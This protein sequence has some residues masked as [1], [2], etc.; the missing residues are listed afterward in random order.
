MSRSYRLFDIMQALRRNREPV[1]ESEV[2][3]ETGVSLRTLYRGIAT[4]Q[5]MG[6]YIDGEPGIG[7]DRP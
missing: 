7:Y 6:A 1:S 4:L 2:A 5:A 3:R